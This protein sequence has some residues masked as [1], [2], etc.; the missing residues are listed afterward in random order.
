MNNKVELRTEF[1]TSAFESR[2]VFLSQ[3][4]FAGASMTLAPWLAGS[5]AATAAEHAESGLIVHTQSPLNAE[6]KLDAL[7]QSWITPVESFY[8]RSH[9][10]NPMIDPASFRLTVEGLVDRPL[11]ISLAELESSFESSS[12]VAT[13]TCA[14]NRRNEHSLI[15]PVKGVPW[16][17]GAIG[18]AKWTGARLSDV[19]KKAGLK[20]S[21]KHVWFEGLDEIPKGDGIIPFGASIPVSKALGDSD[22]VPGALLTTKM[23]D[24][25]L[26]P[27]HGA[28]LR[29]VVPGYVGARSV[30]WLGK[31]VVSDRPSPN[32]YLATAYKLV[33][34]DTAAEWDEAGPI[35]RFPLNSVICTP[36]PGA[37]VAAKKVSVAGYALPSGQPGTSIAKI[38]VST[39]EGRSWTL[40][41]VTSPVR[42]YC[43][44]LWK[45]DVKLSSA[46]S[47]LIVR[48]TDSRGDI[49]P[50]D[51]AWNLKGYMFNGWYHVP[52]TAD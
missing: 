2:R 12:V 16:Q 24:Q 33:T 6:P 52:V 28:P 49:Q 34:E 5:R 31:I 7:V 26:T 48:A 41:K 25:P 1:M 40:A 37:K 19:L 35:Y 27:D 11:S 23:N 39:D 22:A 18:T 47:E 13:M 50:K 29:G 17:A 43:W 14:G 9:A 45:A 3:A 20:D 38:E 32:H 21:A 46:A 44:V 8:V 30:K 15:K 4:S 10:P 42:E 36:A 51:P